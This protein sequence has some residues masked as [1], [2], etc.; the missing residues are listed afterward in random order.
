[1]STGINVTMNFN[2]KQVISDEVIREVSCP[3]TFPNLLDARNSAKAMTNVDGTPLGD[4]LFTLRRNIPILVEMEKRQIPVTDR[5]LIGS[6]FVGVPALMSHVPA[7][8]REKLAKIFSECYEDEQEKDEIYKTARD[9]FLANWQAHSAKFCA[10]YSGFSSLLLEADVTITIAVQIAQ[11]SGEGFRISLKIP[12][13]KTV[14]MD[15]A[16]VEITTFDQKMKYICQKAWS[17]VSLAVDDVS[18]TMFQEALRSTYLPGYP[19]SDISIYLSDYQT[20]EYYLLASEN[21]SLRP[22]MNSIPANILDIF[23]AIRKEYVS[24]YGSQGQVEKSSIRAPSF[25]S[26]SAMCETPGASSFKSLLSSRFPRNTNYDQ[27]EDENG[28]KKS[29]ERITDVREIE[30]LILRLERRIGVIHFMRTFV[31]NLESEI[32]PSQ[33]GFTRLQKALDKSLDRATDFLITLYKKDN[34]L[35]GSVL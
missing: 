5:H 35:R 12:F 16:E 14:E 32:D 15:G 6:R 4:I 10:K 33:R 34:D 19:G 23:Y 21:G 29:K 26:F 3:Y 17:E 31:T 9:L 2:C 28:T 1:M 18:K 7:E 25:S 20:L 24:K 8:E 22:E 27:T 11:F 30:E 13:K